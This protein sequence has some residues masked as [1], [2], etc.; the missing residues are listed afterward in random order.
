[1]QSNVI[2]R[3]EPAEPPEAGAVHAAYSKFVAVGLTPTKENGLWRVK[4]LVRGS[5]RWLTDAELIILARSL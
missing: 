4:K 5:D 1:M 2:P 3:V